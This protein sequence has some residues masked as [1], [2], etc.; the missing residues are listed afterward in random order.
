VLELL[1]TCCEHVRPRTRSVGQGRYTETTRL[2]AGLRHP[3]TKVGPAGAAAAQELRLPAAARKGERGGGSAVTRQSVAG[4]AP[5]PCP[6][7][8]VPPA[9]TSEHKRDG[10]GGFGRELELARGGEA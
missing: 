8:A 6:A 7:R 10:A 3:A 1:S 2:I 9:P 5:L 4:R